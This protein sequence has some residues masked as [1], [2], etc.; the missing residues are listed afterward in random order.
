MDAQAW[1]S[2]LQSIHHTHPDCPRGREAMMGVSYGTGGKP[3]CPECDQLH[4]QATRQNPA[5][6][7]RQK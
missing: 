1:H 6:T 2:S 3:H 7:P 4:Q 5:T